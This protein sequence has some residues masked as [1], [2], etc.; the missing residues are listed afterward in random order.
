MKKSIFNWQ[1]YDKKYEHFRKGQWGRFLT[2]MF[3]AL[4]VVGLKECFFHDTNQ[5]DTQL[6]EGDISN[7]FDQYKSRYSI[8]E[9]KNIAANKINFATSRNT[10]QDL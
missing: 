1:W 2:M 4:F 5:G 9:Q 6:F 3:L 8:E 7:V 10:D